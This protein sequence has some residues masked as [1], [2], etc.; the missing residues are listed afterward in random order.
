MSGCAKARARLPACR[1]DLTPLEAMLC[2][3]RLWMVERAFRTSKSLFVTRPIFHK[4]DE[5]IRGHGVVQLPR[6]RLEKE[7]EDRI[8]RWAS[9]PPPAITRKTVLGPCS[10]RSRVAD[11]DR[12][13]ARRQMLSPALGAAPR[14]EPRLTRRRRRFATDSVLNSPTPDPAPSRRSTE[15]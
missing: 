8:A 9:R 7:L 12:G 10:R 2:Y 11:R 6:P 5:T 14:G 3:K 15:M 1:S 4:L 13:R